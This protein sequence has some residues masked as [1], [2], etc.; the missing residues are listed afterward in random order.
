MALALLGLV[1]PEAEA[2]EIMSGAAPAHL[3]GGFLTQIRAGGRGAGVRHHGGMHHRGMQRPA[4]GMHHA[5]HRPAHG[6]VHRNLNAN[7]NINRNVNRNINRNVNVNRNVHRAVVAPRA[8]WVGRPGW[9]RWPAGGAIAA[10][11]ALGFVTAATAAAWAGAPPQPG[12]CW[13][14]T[15]QSR[16]QGFWDACP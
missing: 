6:N 15:D 1:A 9:Y 13:Y 7:A 11:A 4:G 14:Y 8:A 2:I 12:L 16:T 5:A 3:Q 10:G